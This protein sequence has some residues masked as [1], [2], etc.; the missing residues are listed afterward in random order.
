MKAWLFSVFVMTPF[1]FIQSAL[2][3]LCGFGVYIIKEEDVGTGIFAIVFSFLVLLGVNKIVRLIRF[4]RDTWFG[5]NILDLIVSPLQFPL[6]LIINLIAFIAIFTGW[7]IDAREEPD[8]DDYGLLACI[9]LYLLHISPSYRSKRTS[10]YSTS[11]TSYNDYNSFGYKLKTIAYQFGVLLITV[12]HSPLLL[13]LAS[14]FCESNNESLHD[15]KPFL[16]ALIYIGAFLI[17]IVSTQWSAHLKGV[18]TDFEYWDPNDV[19]RHTVNTWEVR[20][21]L[22]LDRD[23]TNEEINQA[24]ADG[25]YK[26][27]KTEQVNESGWKS[28]FT[29]SMI[30]YFI[31]GLVI[32]INQAI[33][34]LFS[35]I[36][37]AKATVHPCLAKDAEFHSFGAKFLY[38]ILGI[39]ET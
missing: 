35:F 9:G 34:F 33:V 38:F 12:L 36:I 29:L 10:D 25:R 22:G 18:K 28:A 30:L 5:Y 21:A 37:P 31:F 23:P 1:A 3:F 11:Y 15:T 32:V 20:A 19:K 17:Y 8:L 6:I 14:V 7:D 16:D 24:I 26:P 27:I 13:Y 4:G 2:A 39:G